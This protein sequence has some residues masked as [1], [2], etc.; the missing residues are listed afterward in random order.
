MFKFLSHTFNPQ[1]LVAE[2]SYQGT[3]GIIFTEKIKFHAPTIPYYA[4]TIRNRVHATPN[5]T[6][7]LLDRALFLAFILIG[8]SYYKSHP[9]TQVVD[10]Y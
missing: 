6:P 8:T 5:H 4:D 2:F 3:D 9:T 1:T 10:L 7:E